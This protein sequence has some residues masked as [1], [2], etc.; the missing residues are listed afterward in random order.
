MQ[1]SKEAEL[2]RTIRKLKKAEL[3]IRFAQT[4]LA[5]SPDFHAHLQRKKL[6]WD[7]FFDLNNPA[8]DRSQARYR[9]SELALLDKDALKEVIE[10]F[11]WQVYYQLYQENG[12]MHA[13]LYDPALL[14]Q[15]GLPQS[16]DAQAIKKRF[17]ELALK[18]HPDAGGDENSFIQLMEVYR[19]L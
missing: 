10:Q 7:R 5:G 17:R 2:K 13:N 15:L 16:A 11:F 4:G 12:I 9:L 8:S 14:A 3:K 6:V 1:H 19:Q 18:H